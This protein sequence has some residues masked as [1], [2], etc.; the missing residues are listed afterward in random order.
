MPLILLV[1]DSKTMRLV[2]R[3][4]L[5][6][7]G[8]DFV[9]AE[10]GRSALTLLAGPNEIELVISDIRMAGIDGLEL[11]RT[12]RGHEDFGTRVGIVLISGDHSATIRARS[13]LAGADGFLEKPVDPEK[14]RRLVNE[15]L[16]STGATER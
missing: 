3:T 4:H 7:L 2:L 14:L 1:D 10:S 13:F 11:V 15:L 5:T 9:E 8:C 12:I 16:A 6:S